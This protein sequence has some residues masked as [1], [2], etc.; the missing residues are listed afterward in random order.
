MDYSINLRPQ[1]TNKRT[2]L[3]AGAVGFRR[4]VD[5]NPGSDGEERQYERFTGQRQRI[6]QVPER[7]STVLMP[8]VP[9]SGAQEHPP[10]PL[11]KKKITAQL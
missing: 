11:F 3:S 4:R 2:I 8:H 10:S 9:F 6:S 1:Q 7:V 5:A